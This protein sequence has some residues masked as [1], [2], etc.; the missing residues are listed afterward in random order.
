M[1][2]YERTKATIDTASE[3]DGT[4]NSSLDASTRD[5][6]ETRSPEEIEREIDATRNRMTRDIDAIGKKLKPSNLA[7]QAGD[8]ISERARETG[9]GFLELVRDNPLPAAAVGASVAWL[10]SRARSDSTTTNRRDRGGWDAGG[11][12]SQFRG[13]NT[14]F[15]TRFTDVGTDSESDGRLSHAKDAV[16]DAASNVAEKAHDL[17]DR[18][19]ET[20]TELGGKAKDWTQHATEDVGNQLQRARNTLEEKTRENPLLIAAGAAVLGVALGFLLPSTR[21]ENELMGATRDE[22]ADRAEATVERVKDVATEGARHVADTVKSEVQDHAPEIKNIARDIGEHVKHEAKDAATQVAS[23]AK[24]TA[25][26]GGSGGMSGGT[27]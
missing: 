14:E 1:N 12:S 18:A 15:R 24:T 5:A 19:Q 2:E 26:K 11:R 20:V 8:A 9:K 3:H 6:G 4:F 13:R 23:E 25:R 27:T 16:S 10:V 21:K 17:T 22:I 7:H